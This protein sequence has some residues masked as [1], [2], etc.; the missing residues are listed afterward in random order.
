MFG[1]D[2]KQ[3][4]LLGIDIGSTAVK[5]IELSKTGAAPTAPYQ[6]DRYAIEPLAA[7]AMSEKKIADTQAVAQAIA[8]AVQRSGTKARRAAVAVSGSAVIT[9]VIEMADT[10]SEAD[11]E[12]QLQF[13]ADQY[14]PFPL[15]E[16]NLDFDVLGPSSRPGMV[17]VLIAASRSENIDDRVTALDD[18]GLQAE[19]VD[20]EGYALENAC[21]LMGR[22][23][24]N[25]DLTEQVVALTDIGSATTTL[26][27]MHKG[28][29]VY[30]REQKF[31]GSQL[32]NEIQQRLGIPRDEAI[33]MI[34][35]KGLK[36]GY[37][38]EVVAPFKEAVA[39]QIGRALQF[40]Y[41]ATSYS[42]A[43][44]VLLAGATASLPQLDRLVEDRLGIATEVGNP[45]ETMSIAKGV[46]LDDLNR[47]AP[48]LIL[49]VGLAL[50][51]FI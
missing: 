46:P 33:A 35:T 23:D 2:R 29:V 47:D 12:A 8:R 18:A 20:V 19:I 43:D 21:R 6:V 10:L 50:R 41:S 38:T 51:G 31:G 42:Q 4:P 39:Q 9:K 15:N 11:M 40:F 5:L 7:N 37:Q 30:T 48:S 14:I 32:V 44:H 49:A 26:H 34:A 17:N 25:T 1:L 45:F 22:S 36:G 28:Q 3:S 16:V 27:V 13:D 24:A